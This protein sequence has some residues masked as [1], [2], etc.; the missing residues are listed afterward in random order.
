MEA[1]TRIQ[2]HDEL[3]KNLRSMILRG[4]LPPGTRVA[5]RALCERFGVSR[6]PLREALKVLAAGG[7]V[8]LLPNRGAWVAPL[9]GEDIR[10]C[11]QVVSLLEVGA[12]E[13]I[14]SRLSGAMISDLRRRHETMVLYL[15]VGDFEGGVRLDLELHRTLVEAAGNRQLAATHRELALQVERA[16]YFAALSEERMRQSVQEHEAILDAA[17]THDLRAL[18]DAVRHH[19]AMTEIAVVQAVERLNAEAA[20]AA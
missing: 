15:R 7:L 19:C 1:I 5:E 14:A 20:S 12:A 13:M 4:L 6:T 10:N 9:R 2:L 3:L 16:R 18:A 8:E 17:E 11:F